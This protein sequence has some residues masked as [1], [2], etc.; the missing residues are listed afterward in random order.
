VALPTPA[1]YLILLLFWGVYLS[2]ARSGL[3]QAEARVLW[4]VRDDVPLN[5]APRDA[6]RG[7]RTNVEQMVER[8]EPVLL[9]YYAIM[10]A[11]VTVAG[12]SVLAA[13]YF[14]ALCI[15]LAA[16]LA[17]RWRFMLV[18]AG[19]GALSAATVH[20]YAVGILV[21]CVIGASGRAVV[22]R[23]AQWGVRLL[24]GAAAIAGIIIAVV[25]VGG[26]PD[27][28]G[29]IG[30]FNAVRTADEPAITGF[31]ADSPLAHY[32][33]QHQTYFRR[34]INV[35]SGW[36]DFSQAEIEQIVAALDGASAIW[37]V[38]VADR[39]FEAALVESGYHLQKSGEYFTRYAKDN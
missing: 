10:D 21:L 25:I 9:P 29:A 13:R 14:S 30:D 28:T 5:V 12:E 11:W 4:T 3:T 36:R 8:A 34:W 22:R 32:D 37:L 19:L 17:A 24:H 6:L 38:D 7:L 18:V 27:W 2:L 20:V 35:N 23:D 31:A 26:R 39:Q 16:V 1:R 33:R 15:L